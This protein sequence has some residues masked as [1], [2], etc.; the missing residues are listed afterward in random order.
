MTR[1]L[2]IQPQRAAFDRA[3]VYC[4]LHRV[5]ADIRRMATFH[6]H[7]PSTGCDTSI[8]SV[9]RERGT[10]RST[11]NCLTPGC[12]CARGKA[13]VG[14]QAQQSETFQTRTSDASACCPAQSRLTTSCPRDETRHTNK[15]STISERGKPENDWQERFEVSRPCGFSKMH[16]PTSPP[17]SGHPSSR[18]FS[19]PQQRS[20]TPTRARLKLNTLQLSIS[21][22]SHARSAK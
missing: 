16:V 17:I 2:R 9:T 8:F 10:L 13:I 11:E 7:N 19:R 20:G 15:R 14:C 21:T 22:S 3:L 18:L 1:K 4:L 12:S 6:N 5:K